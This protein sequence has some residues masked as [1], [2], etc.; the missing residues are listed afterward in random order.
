[1]EIRPARLDDLPDLYEVCLLTGDSGKDA[2][3]IYQIP[4]L[5]GEIYVGPYV[6]LSPSHSFALVDSEDVAVGYVLGALDTLEFER[7]RKEVWLPPLRDKYQPY[8]QGTNTVVS[9]ADSEL[10]DLIF[11][12]SEPPY[13]FLDQFPSHGHIDIHPEYQG[14]GF[15]VTM[16]QELLN[17]LRT[18][19]SPGIYMPVSA[20]NL[21][22]LGFYR[23]LGF[24][25][26]V[27]RGDEVIIGLK[28]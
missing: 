14:R 4:D 27:V 9:S 18:Q 22:A 1:M 15:G 8:Y 20:A 23:K 2:R 3:G 24:T 13:E 5:L 21:N 26:L 25:E 28:F 19:N 11:N 17:S 12:P 7:L 10:I 6:A 16:M